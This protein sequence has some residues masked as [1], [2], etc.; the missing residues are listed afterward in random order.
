MRSPKSSAPW[1]GRRCEPSARALLCP[2]MRVGFDVSALSRP[3]SRGLV[4]VVENL[5][6]ALERR[7]E[8]ELVRLAPERGVDLLRWRQ[9]ELPRLASAAGCLGVHSST[10]AFPL[11]AA[12]RVQTVH[13]L[14]WR[15]GV[16][17]N[18]DLRHRLWASLGSARA[19]R[20]VVPS[21]FVAA[22]LARSPFVASAKIRVVP[23]GVEARFQPEPPPM[24]VDEAL[25]TRYRLP[26]GPYLFCPG[27]V[28]AKKNLSALLYGLAER[29]QRKSEPLRVLLTGGDTPQLRSD[30]GLASKLGL[31]RWVSML[32]EIADADLPS[33]YRLA[34]AVPVLSHSEGFGL[35]V[36]EA[37]ACG[38]PVLVPC[39]SAPSEVAGAAGLA[40]DPRSPAEL[41]DALER[42]ASERFELR[43]RGLARA[44]EFTWDAAAEKVAALWR[45]LA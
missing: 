16:R 9:R 24:T 42:V 13:E 29:Q 20:V 39:A 3:H 19:Q 23:W 31:G 6:G 7:G 27:A 35:P 34:Y 43:R 28:R 41:A 36:L 1:R 4:R 17:E 37:M 14:P 5:L 21:A 40:L 44:Q 15:H 11:G 2:D 12:R 32:D 22:D 33:V 26:E 30:L 18:A 10:S 25:F 45:E 8:L 38:T